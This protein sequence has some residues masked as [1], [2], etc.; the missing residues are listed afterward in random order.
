MRRWGI[1]LVALAVAVL[2]GTPACGPTVRRAS[3]SPASPP[4]L[5]ELWQAPDDLQQ[6]DLFHGAGGASLVPRA[7]SFTFVAKDKGGYS[8]GF[9]VRDAEGI[10]WSVKL[11]PEAQTEVTTSRI[12]WS[13]GFHQP[14]TYYLSQW[15]MSGDQSGTQ[16]GGR[17]R[18]TLPGHSVVGDWSWYDNPFMNFRE[19]RG[20]VVA[21]LILNN[22][23]WKTSNNKIYAIAE[24][25]R[26]PRRQF[27]V[28]DLGASL[29][30]TSYP[31][32]LKWLGLR[33]FGQGS[34]NDVDG[35]EQQGFILGLNADSTVAFDYRG[36]HGNLVETLSPADVRWTCEL[37]SRLTDQQWTDAFRAGGFSPETSNR[38]I[39][40][41][42]AKL[43]QGLA[44]PAATS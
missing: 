41:I 28:R 1:G 37:L 7:E 3:T 35:F 4:V 17:F 11:G 19:F 12:L 42:K 2:G 18:P 27:V 40:K 9:D 43:A 32:W 15:R 6:R 24:P 26:A 21:N 23:D 13:V 44:L 8:P 29:G 16:P 14:P 30:K 34:R 38:Y 39:Q 10:E 33:G 25:G 22:W 36:I 20:L 31:T 5:E